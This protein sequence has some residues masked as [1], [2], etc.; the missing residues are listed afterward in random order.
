MGLNEAR[1]RV[2][3]RAAL[4]SLIKDPWL[5]AES[6]K[7]RGH[8]HPFYDWLEEAWGSP[9]IDPFLEA[10]EVAVTEPLGG[11]VQ[12]RRNRLTKDAADHWSALCELY[13]ATCLH[14]C[15]FDVKRS[16]WRWRSGGGTPG[17]SASSGAWLPA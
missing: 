1:A 10:L 16:P 17:S 8:W 5:V 11:R 14:R 13:L 2:A 15:G 12:S 7:G 4:G 9:V 6:V 3:R